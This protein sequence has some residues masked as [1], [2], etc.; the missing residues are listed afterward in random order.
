MY[1]MAP[2]TRNGI[3]DF[4][5]I[6]AHRNSDARTLLNENRANIENA[7]GDYL[8]CSGNGILLEPI[9]IDDRV[10]EALKTNFRLLDKGRSH[11]SIR[12]E[13]LGSARFDAC[14]YCNATTVDSLDHALPRTVYPEF[15]VLAQNL[16]PACGQCNRKKG[17]ECFKKSGVN[18][19][20]SLFRAYS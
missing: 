13:I 7:Y 2:P 15:S 8:T 6:V 14:P 17:E 1:S 4:D 10:A 12:D 18:L 11:S 20:A 3:E 16:V 19:D 9:N 5:G